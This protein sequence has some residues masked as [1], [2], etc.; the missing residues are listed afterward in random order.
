M[1]LVGEEEQLGRYATHAGDGEGALG[2]GVLDAEVLL[3]VDA[4]DGS[5][6]TVDIQMRR[7]FEHLGTLALSVLVPGCLTHIPVGEP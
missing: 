3:S 2:L 4:E 1:V 6:P 7:G 5:V